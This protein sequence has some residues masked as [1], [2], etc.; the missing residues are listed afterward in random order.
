MFLM[1]FKFLK[2]FKE[3]CFMLFFFKMINWFVL[4][5]NMFKLDV[6]N[7][8]FLFLFMIKGEEDLV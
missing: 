4:G 7:I 3:I 8:S 6:K 2:F 5:V 1:C